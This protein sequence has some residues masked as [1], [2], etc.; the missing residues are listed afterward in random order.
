MIILDRQ[1]GTLDLFEVACDFEVEKEDDVAVPSDVLV[2]EQL[3]GV[4]DHED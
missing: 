4:A 1:Q 3:P 2:S